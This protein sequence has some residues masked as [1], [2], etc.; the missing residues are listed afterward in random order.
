MQFPPKLRGQ[1]FQHQNR[2]LIRIAWRARR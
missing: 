1:G 2:D